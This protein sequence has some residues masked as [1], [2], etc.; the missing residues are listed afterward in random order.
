MRKLLLG[1]ALSTA[2]LLAACGEMEE[3]TEETDTSTAAEPAEKKLKRNQQKLKI[4]KK[5]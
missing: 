1:T 2:L 3:P 4:L 5:L